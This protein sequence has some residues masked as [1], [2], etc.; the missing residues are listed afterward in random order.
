MSLTPGS[1]WNSL[2]MESDPAPTRPRLS[3]SGRG[4]GYSGG[5]LGV[6]PG[7]PERPDGPF[8]PAQVRRRPDDPHRATQDPRDLDRPPLAA[9]AARGRVVAQEEA[10]ARAE[11]LR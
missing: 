10:L 1:S 7:R 3:G 8:D 11:I 9:V 2:G 4:R 6:R 5:I